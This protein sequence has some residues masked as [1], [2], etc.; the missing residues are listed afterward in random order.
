MKKY[1]LSSLLVLGLALYSTVAA[2]AENVVYGIMP[3][4]TYGARTTSFD[5]DALGS[6]ALKLTPEF[7]FE[8]AEEFNCGTSVGDKYYAFVVNRGVD[9]AAFVTLNFTTGNMVVVNDKSFCLQS[10]A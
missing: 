9:A 2:W 8:N 3:S 1:L 6:D 7:A 10:R 4:N 5:I